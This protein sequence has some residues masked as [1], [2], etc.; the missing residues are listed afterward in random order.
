MHN[1]SCFATD[2][3]GLRHW[4]STPSHQTILISHHLASE[5]S[6]NIA[7]RLSS[8][9][10]AYSGILYQLPHM[11]QPSSVASDIPCVRKTYFSSR[12]LGEGLS[13][14][15]IWVIPRAM[16]FW[17]VQLHLQHPLQKFGVSKKGNVCYTSFVPAFQRHLGLMHP[18]C[19]PIVAEL[20]PLLPHGRLRSVSHTLLGASLGAVVMKWRTGRGNW[21][22]T[23]HLL[24]D[25]GS[26]WIEGVCKLSVLLSLRYLTTVHIKL[27][28]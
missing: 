27:E 17:L 8:I 20:T 15:R 14:G 24:R 25:I 1:L 22:Q 3:E 21:M 28:A 5:I 4:N 19:S 9:S 18:L 26:G 10:R 7:Q 12:F 23:R 2:G 6:A 11:K 16:P 13:A